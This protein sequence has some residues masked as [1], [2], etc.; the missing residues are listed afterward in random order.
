MTTKNSLINKISDYLENRQKTNNFGTCRRCQK[1]VYWSTTK[2][3]SHIRSGHCSGTSEDEVKRF[4]NEFVYDSP[5]NLVHI[6]K[7][8]MA[9][10]E[11]SN[12]TENSLVK[13]IQVVN[14]KKEDESGHK[15]KRTKLELNDE[16]EHLLDDEQT[17]ST[18]LIYEMESGQCDDADKMEEIYFVTEASSSNYDKMASKTQH[19]LENKSSSS[20]LNT[21]VNKE[22]KFISVV[23]PQFKGYSK[24]NLIDEILDLK[25]RNE[26]LQE[27]I[28]KYEDT[29]HKLI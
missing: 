20:T 19:H 6:N 27:K 3:A 10:I 17:E 1:N 2:V 14:L 8:I 21:A 9:K 15:M 23:Y 26:L 5:K 12:T 28:K 24:M 16:E 22:E 13:C 25:R 7:S 4:K 11:K 18:E 29:I